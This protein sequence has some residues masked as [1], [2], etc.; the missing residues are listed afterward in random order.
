[1]NSSTMLTD[2]AVEAGISLPHLT[3]PCGR[4]TF[5]TNGWA[6]P[7]YAAATLFLGLLFLNATIAAAFDEPTGINKA[8]FGMT[9]AELLKEYPKAH[10]V[11][12]PTVA[13][14]DSFN[15]ES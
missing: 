11:P 9:T 2:R 13:P 12:R 6:K 4:G 15:L 5:L 7:C 1:M 8:R 3:S 10:L 14:G